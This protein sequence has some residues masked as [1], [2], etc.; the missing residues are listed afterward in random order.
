[1]MLLSKRTKI[2][3]LRY[4]CQFGMSMLQNSLEL[5]V[6]K[7]V[8]HHSRSHRNSLNDQLSS[9]S[10]KMGRKVSLELNMYK[11]LTFLIHFRLDS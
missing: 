1:M 8:F 11:V 5:N 7:D 4:H 2:L 6:E 9:F 10:L 3:L